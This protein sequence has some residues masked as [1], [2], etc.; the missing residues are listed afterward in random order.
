[1]EMKHFFF[2]FQVGKN[3]KPLKAKTTPTTITK[4]LTTK[5]TP[6]PAKTTTKTPISTS[7]F[8]CIAISE[9]RITQDAIPHNLEI[10]NYESLEF[11]DC[12]V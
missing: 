1:M 2:N 9:T 4:T 5:T 6:T 11:Q 8:Q 12:E 10:P 3:N 7:W